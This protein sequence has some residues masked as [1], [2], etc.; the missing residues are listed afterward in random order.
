[1][2]MSKLQLAS[3]FFVTGVD[4]QMLQK[5]IPVKRHTKTSSVKPIA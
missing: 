3:H 4:L 2:R 5:H 1:M